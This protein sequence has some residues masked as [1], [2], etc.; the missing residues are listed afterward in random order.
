M[1]GCHLRRLV[2]LNMTS[3]GLLLLVLSVPG[4]G[5]LLRTTESGGA[6]TDQKLW[7]R[8][9]IICLNLRDRPYAKQKDLLAFLYRAIHMQNVILNLVMLFT[10]TLHMKVFLITGLLPDLITNHSGK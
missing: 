4:P 2:R 3:L 1:D 9:E 10:V 7:V 5:L 8:G 6:A